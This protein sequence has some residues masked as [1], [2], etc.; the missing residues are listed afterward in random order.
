VID[1]TD[2]YAFDDVVFGYDPTRQGVLFTAY[3]ADSWPRTT[4]SIEEILLP[5]A[6]T[7]HDNK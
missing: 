3:Y 6:N 1:K 7:V 2:G 4:V 5:R